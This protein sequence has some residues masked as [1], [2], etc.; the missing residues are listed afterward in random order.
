MFDTATIDAFGC[1][2]IYFTAQENKTCNFK[3]LSKE[4]QKQYETIYYP[5]RKK[6]FEVCK[7]PCSSMSIYLGFPIISDNNPDRAYVKLYFKD[8]I[9]VRRNMRAYSEISLFAEL[10]GYVGL[11]LGFSLLDLKKIIN[12]L[13]DF[14]K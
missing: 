3:D 10:G 4:Q 9:N 1:S 7:L 11:L 13:L 8:N 5:S 14:K 12:L 6:A 2:A